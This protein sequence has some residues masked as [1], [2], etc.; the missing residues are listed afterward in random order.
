[1]N[2][3]TA[4]PESHLALR[5]RYNATCLGFLRDRISSIV[6]RTRSGHQPFRRLPVT[7]GQ[8]LNRVNLNQWPDPAPIL[9]D[10]EA[11]C[12]TIKTQISKEQRRPP[13]RRQDA[14]EPPA[15]DL[16]TLHTALVSAAHHARR[17]NATYRQIE[18]QRARK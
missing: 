11:H 5:Y 8:F 3:F 1:M 18:A 6:H 15:D 9:E 13:F 7:M 14:P 12:R 10:I 17:M 2:R 4:K 16:T